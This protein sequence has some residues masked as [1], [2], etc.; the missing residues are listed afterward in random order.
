MDK[1]IWN[2]SFSVGVNELDDQH[3]KLIEMINNLIES[4]SCTFDSEVISVTLGRMIEYTQY[5]FKTEEQYMIDHDFLGYSVHED[6]HIHFLEQA[7]NFCMNIQSG[8]KKVPSELLSFLKDWLAN[9]ILKLD[10][11]YN[12]TL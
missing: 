4:E 12:P 3:Q 7:T 9:H 8:D 2:N 10:M 1:I 5:H 11:K 6:E